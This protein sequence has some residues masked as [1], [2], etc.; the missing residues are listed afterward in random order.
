LII[1]EQLKTVVNSGV[2][3]YPQQEKQLTNKDQ[4]QDR[5]T[6]TIFEK[7]LRKS[8]VVLKFG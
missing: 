3:M 2:A 6:Q 4:V 8:M 5:M 1:I 7:I